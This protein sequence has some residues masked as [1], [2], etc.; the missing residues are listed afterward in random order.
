MLTKLDIHV[1]SGSQTSE[2]LETFLQQPNDK[3]NFIFENFKTESNTPYLTCKDGKIGFL[4]GNQKLICVDFTDINL[5]KRFAGTS[6]KDIFI[7]ALYSKNK[8][9]EV[10]CDM[11]AGFATD[12]LIA[13][14]YF[15]K[16]ILVEKNPLVALM[17]ADGLRRAKLH[18]KAQ[19]FANKVTLMLDESKKVL[20]SWLD[21]KELQ[22]HVIYFDFM[23][24]DKKTLS[25]KPLE[26]LK[27]LTS[28]ELNPDVV[29]SPKEIIDLA[30]R[31][32][33][34]QVVLKAKKLAPDL[35]PKK[36]FPGKVVNYYQFL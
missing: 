32:E 19:I 21:K 35:K 22:S 12:A 24:E 13:S 18:D 17:L 14:K 15:K 23:F 16:V 36:T 5:L 25:S 4:Q 29:T 20:A 2:L 31:L 26:L 10:L 28:Q 27:N 7:K 8:R 33:P 11:T 30:L 1:D 6:T 3:Y 9:P 34:Q